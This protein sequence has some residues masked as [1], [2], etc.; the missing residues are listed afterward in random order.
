MN[1]HHTDLHLIN[2][3]YADDITLIQAHQKNSK[4]LWSQRWRKL[5]QR[6]CI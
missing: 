1:K 6:D 4:Q 2:L 5:R 3:R